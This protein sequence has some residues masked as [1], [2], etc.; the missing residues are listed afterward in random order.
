MNH[1]CMHN[2]TMDVCTTCK[3]EF[4]S[5]AKYLKHVCTCVKLSQVDEGVIDF[6]SFLLE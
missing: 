5:R 2:N 6:D 3:K 4:R 1:L